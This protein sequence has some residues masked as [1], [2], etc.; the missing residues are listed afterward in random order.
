MAGYR[1]LTACTLGSALGQ[2]LVMSMGELY[3]ILLICY[4]QMHQSSTESNL[5]AT[6]AADNTSSPSATVPVTS[7]PESQSGS[8]L[9]SD[10]SVPEQPPASTGDEGEMQAA[11]SSQMD[12]DERKQRFICHCCLLINNLF[13]CIASHC[14]AIVMLPSVCLS[15]LYCDKTTEARITW[16]LL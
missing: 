3:L 4:T 9:V 13:T 7:V 12:F 16:F 8:S 14:L 6:A 15:C 11:A 5:L 2:C 1:R 10:G